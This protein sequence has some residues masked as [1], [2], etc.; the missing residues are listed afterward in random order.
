MSGKTLTYKDAGVDISA[1]D[2]FVAMIRERV[3]KAWPGTAKEISGFAGQGYI[4]KNT[5]SLAAS[6]DGVGTKL[7][8][9]AIMGMFD[10]VGQDAVAMSA[11]DTYVNGQKP[12]FL[13][14]Y[15]ATGKFEP[16]KHIKVIESVIRGCLLAGCKLIGGETAEM[17]GFFRYDWMVDLVTSVIG[18]PIH[19]NS[20]LPGDWCPTE[21]TQR[22]YGWLSNG[23]ASNGYSLIRKVFQLNGSPSKV[24]KRLNRIYPDL[25]QCSLADVLLA[26]TPIWIREIERAKQRG[27]TFSGHAHITG[28]GLVENPPRILPKSLK[29]V[30][31]K[32]SW[33]RPPI[34]RL[35]QDK[36]KVPIEDMDRTFNNGIMVI[37]IVCNCSKPLDN[38]NAVEIVTIE[39][40]R[41]ERESQVVFTGEYND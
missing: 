26:P 13:L 37:S 8:I 5:L 30:I 7:K 41:R 38:E 12:A 18:F 25:G 3:G 9:A 28:G 22:V 11:V 4:P 34:F 32:T 24:W 29:M 31:D 39:K 14:D 19:P 27:V 15:F 1:A 21:P 17:P 36:G 35:I 16:E 6:N 2:M 33:Q 23:P 10:G 40:R 20:C